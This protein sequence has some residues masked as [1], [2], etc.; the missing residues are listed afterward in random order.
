MPRCLR[1]QT[2]AAQLALFGKGAQLLAEEGGSAEAAEDPGEAA[3]EGAEASQSQDEVATGVQR[4]VIRTA[5]AEAVD[6]LLR[7]QVCGQDDHRS[8]FP[9]PLPLTPLLWAQPPPFPFWS[10]SQ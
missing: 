6:L 5:G 2:A 7:Y 1:W 8:P 3:S 9:P 10:V 4:H